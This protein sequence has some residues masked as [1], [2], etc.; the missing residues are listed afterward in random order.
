[1]VIYD[2][3]C[4]NGHTFEGWFDNKEEM[5]SQQAQ[6]LLQ[7]P[8]CESTSINRKVHPIAIKT[9]STPAAGEPGS[10]T[11][12]QIPD[13]SALQA[14]QERLSEYTEKMAKFVENNFDNV[15]ASFTQDALNMHYG[16]SEHR[17]IRGTTTS[18]DDKVLAK[19]GIPVMKL[20]V[21]KSDKE[22]LN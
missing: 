15:G 14:A 17:N 10:H 12:A 2:L 4:H 16:V 9:R 22:D 20:P 5:E 3:E 13:N 1:M 19:E 7:C 8:V 18:E 6:G 11:S 21:T